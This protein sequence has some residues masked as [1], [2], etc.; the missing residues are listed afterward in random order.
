[1]ENIKRL[2]A[3]LA[4]IESYEMDPRGPLRGKEDWKQFDAHTQNRL[5]AHTIQEIRGEQFANVV[6]EIWA[7]W[8]GYC[9]SICTPQDNGSLVIPA[10]KVERWNRQA[11][12]PF[13]ELSE[14]EKQSDRELVLRFKM[15]EI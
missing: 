15:L 1:M 10:D 9:H 14:K 12:T 11:A 8:I 2:A 13:S 5:N 4:A 6:H 7:N 3:L